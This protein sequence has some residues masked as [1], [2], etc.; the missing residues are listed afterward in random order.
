M[1][2]LVNKGYKRSRFEQ[3]GAGR[4]WGKEMFRLL[5]VK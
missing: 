4:E 3:G 1:L 5:G 2:I